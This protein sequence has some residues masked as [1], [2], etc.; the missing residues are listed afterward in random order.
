M[1]KNVFSYVGYAIKARKAVFGVDNLFNKK[2]FVV[3]YDKSL[4]DNSKDR[5]MKYLSKSNTKGF[6]VDVEE[7][8]PNKNCKAIGISDRN[9][10]SA[11]IKEMEGD[12]NE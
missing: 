10:A 9:L 11:I 2:C 4:S 1:K 3:L 5:V 7:L 8:Y 6:V 12:L